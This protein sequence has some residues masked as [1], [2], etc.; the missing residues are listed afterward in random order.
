M[1]KILQRNVK[2]AEYKLETARQNLEWEKRNL[3]SLT[4]D[5]YICPRKDI[6]VEDVS[7]L[8]EGVI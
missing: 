4:V 1:R 2:D 5:D 8:D 7:Y 6:S 3:E